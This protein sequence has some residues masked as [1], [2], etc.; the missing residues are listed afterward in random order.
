MRVEKRLQNFH[1]V[2]SADEDRVVIAGP[3]A[4]EWFKQRW[5]IPHHELDFVGYVGVDRVPSFIEQRQMDRTSRSSSASKDSTG[6]A[7]DLGKPEPSQVCGTRSSM[8]K[9]F[10]CPFSFIRAGRIEFVVSCVGASREAPDDAR[11]KSAGGCVEDRLRLSPN[12]NSQIHNGGGRNWD[13]K[14]LAVRRSQ[15]RVQ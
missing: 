8:N 13:R 9:T 4:Q 7:R 15:S 5:T 10:L 3:V 11:R 6:R 1:V 14:R 2:R 12:R